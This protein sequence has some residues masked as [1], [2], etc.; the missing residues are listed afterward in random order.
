MWENVIVLVLNL[1]REFFFFSSF[2]LDSRYPPA[3]FV[4]FRV[5]LLVCFYFFVFCF[6]IFGKKNKQV[7]LEFEV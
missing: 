2:F 5:S 6:L 7:D 1:Q 4:L 3:C